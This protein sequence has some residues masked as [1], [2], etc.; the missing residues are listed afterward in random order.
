MSCKP[1]T[2]ETFTQWFNRQKF[3]NFRAREFTW[4]WGRVNRGVKNSPPPRSTWANIVPTLRIL[5]DL[6]DFYD[7]PITLTSTYRSLAYNRSVGSPDGSQHRRFSAVDFKVAN[8]SPAQV[9]SQ[10]RLMRSRRGFT[11]GIGTYRSFVHL[12]TRKTNATW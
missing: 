8:V 6:R 1:K 2:N 5:D 10:L 9:G 12:D 11:A 4:M 3:R 7:Q